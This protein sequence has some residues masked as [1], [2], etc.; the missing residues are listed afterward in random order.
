MWLQQA[1]ATCDCLLAPAQAFEIFWKTGGPGAIR[2]RDLCL[3]RA[4]LYPAELR[5]RAAPCIHVSREGQPVFLSNIWLGA[6][7]IANQAL[8]PILQ[9]YP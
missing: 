7:A 3:R 5:V 6:V 2:T 1:E 8:G 4:T 9:S